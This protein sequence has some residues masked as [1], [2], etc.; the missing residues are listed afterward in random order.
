MDKIKLTRQE[1]Y[2]QVWSHPLTELAQKY[3]L[4]DNGLRK[5][6]NTYAIPI[7]Q[8]GYWQKIKAKKTVIVVKLPKNYTGSETIELPLRSEHN[9]QP[10]ALS[11]Q[12]ARTKEI[13]SDSKAPLVVTDHLVKPH[14]LVRNTKEYWSMKDAGRKRDE[15][16]DT[17]SIR[18]EKPNRKRALLFMNA[19]IK[20]LEYRGHSIEKGNYWGT[21]AIVKGIGIPIYLREATKR[22]PGKGIYD[23]SEYI[24]TGQLVLKIGKYSGEKEFKDGVAKIEVMLAKIVAKLEII[25]EKEVEWKERSRINEE[26]R[27]AEQKVREE[28]IIRKQKEQQQ[29]DALMTDAEQFNKAQT[30]RV[31]IAAVKAKHPLTGRSTKIQEWIDWATKKADWLDPLVKSGDSIMDQEIH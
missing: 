18:V 16:I 31:Y 10:S 22:I 4:S 6:C 19:L 21:E 29:F 20:L 5:I 13:T 2:D 3:L 7:P 15:K 9:S 25:A 27:A 14:N 11:L 1:L 26:Q 8:N 24:P 17:L 12:I 30:I 23:S 28:L